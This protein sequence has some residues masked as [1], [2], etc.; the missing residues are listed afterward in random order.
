VVSATD[1]QG[2]EARIYFD[3]GRPIKEAKD[4]NEEFKNIF[5]ERLRT[6]KCFATDGSKWR[7]NHS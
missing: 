5:L 2:H 7:T 4:H 3:E 6:S 1:S